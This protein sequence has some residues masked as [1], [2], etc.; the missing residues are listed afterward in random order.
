MKIEGNLGFAKLISN[1]SY[2]HRKEQ[3]GYEGTLYNLGF[4]QAGVFLNGDG[5]SAS[6]PYPLLDNLGVHLPPGATDYR[7]PNSIDNGQQ[8]ITQEI[9]LQSADATSP[10]FWTAG[11]FFS[12]DR[13]T[14]SRADSRSAAQ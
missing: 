6:T 10:L 14:L 9:R 1:T 4:Y 2:F 11:A 13:Q 3:T 5:S 7:S 12:S 8:N